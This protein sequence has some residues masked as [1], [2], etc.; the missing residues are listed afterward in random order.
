[1]HDSGGG[2]QEVA[3]AVRELLLSSTSTAPSSKSIRNED[4]G[5]VFQNSIYPFAVERNRWSD[6]DSPLD[7]SR[8][9][10][11]SSPCSDRQTENTEDGKSC[12]GGEATQTMRSGSQ[13]S[14]ARQARQPC[15]EVQ[16]ERTDSRSQTSLF[17]QNP[18]KHD[19]P[20]VAAAPDTAA[21]RRSLPD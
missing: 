15:G 2:R 14:F 13:A 19:S 3:D 5:A 7:S 16:T 12:T 8:Q 20:G 10:R 17:P 11:S 18:R 6:S 9:K 21:G 4:H 1:M